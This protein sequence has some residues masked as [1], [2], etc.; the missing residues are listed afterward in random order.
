M[1]LLSRI[2]GLVRDMVFSRLYGAGPLM[3]AFLV[4]FRIPNLGRRLFAEGAFSQ[5]FVPVISEFRSTRAH[6]EVRELADSVAG[7]LGLF[8]FLFTLAGVLAAPL[9]I[10]VF[11]PGFADTPAQHDLTVAMLR[12]TFPYLFFISL[13]ALAGGIL[14]TYGRFGVPAFTPVLLNVVL[15]AFAIWIAPR[16][17]EPGIGLAL[18]VFVAGLVQLLFQLPFLARVRV[19]PRPRWG[20]PHEGVRRIGRLMLPALFGSSVAQLNILIDTLIASLLAAG[21][22]SWL[23]Y[24][25]RLV[26]FPLGVFGIA[27]ATVILPRLAEQ[28]ARS[29]RVTFAATLDWALRLV[30]LIAVPAALGL[31]VLAGPLMATLF[32]RGEFTAADVDM[33][34]AGLCAYAPGLIGFILVKVLAPGYFARQDT[35]TPVRVGVQALGLGMLLNVVF[36]LALVRYPWAPA[37]V[38]I[39]AATSVSGLL[40]GMLLLRGLLRSG[41][42]RPR[43]GW[44]RLLVQ[45]LGASAVM[46][47]VLLFALRHAENWLLL[48]SL[49]RVAALAV[50]VAG[51]A[52]VYFA[53]CYAFGLRPRELRAQ[54]ARLD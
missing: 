7:T 10:Y 42:Y 40:N 19:L 12:L 39:A 46:T 34:A 6:E 25:E 13:T 27:I 37:H 41:I 9:F 38:G 8:L 50:F 33:A 5:A 32:Y 3:D 16:M 4:A 11:A 20:W 44:G 47:A 26:E 51:A 48:G 35:R 36:V 14:N 23:Y 21:S 45:V 28:H 49:E 31:A 52:A 43:A 53:A 1:T 2:L 29:S 18:G 30:L 15:I 22:I 54:R 17:P 24:S